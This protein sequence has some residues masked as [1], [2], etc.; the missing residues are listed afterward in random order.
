VRARALAIGLAA[1]LMTLGLPATSPA[2]PKHFDPLFEQ[3]EFK[4][5]ASNGYKLTF[6]RFDFSPG[7]RGLAVTNATASKGLASVK[8]EALTRATG[9][10][11][12][13]LRLPDGGL[14]SVRFHE[15]G[16]AR[17]RPPPNCSGPGDL[18]RRGV[19]IGTIRL[20]G[21]NGFTRVEATAA[22]GTITTTFEEKCSEGGSKQSSDG[23]GL[24]AG[25]S[26]V[27]TV[28]GQ[29]PQGEVRVTAYKVASKRGAAS[30][31][32]LL[33]SSLVRHQGGT[34]I[35]ETQALASRDISWFTTESQ[36]RDLSATLTPES[37]FTGTADFQREENGSYEWTGTLGAEMPISGVI[38]LAEP[39][40]KEALCID[41]RCV[42]KDRETA[43]FVA[44]FLL[45]PSLRAAAPTPIPL[46]R[47]GFPR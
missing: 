15:Q 6:G 3:S 25:R 21:E 16:R 42:G 8:Y 22:K 19:A 12:L 37:P 11:R 32:S 9:A 30:D 29:V 43:S 45:R 28:T 46:P 31:V 2:K 35:T 26:A 13:R 7:A 41:S 23:G 34:S 47:P 17:H 5:A 18:V 4:L 33:I 39:S 14:I 10:D 36:G 40:F 38:P 44:A 20:L 24:P 27:L 1:M